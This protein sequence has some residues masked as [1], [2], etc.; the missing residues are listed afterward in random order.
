M[1]HII[2]Y[3]KFYNIIQRK[4]PCIVYFKDQSYN[5]NN[6]VMETMD[7]M[8]KIYPMVLCYEVNWLDRQKN[9]I[10]KIIKC[11]F[12]VICFK[13]SKFICKISPFN[14]SKLHF[15]FKTV[16]NDSVRNYMKSF[17]RI[18]KMEKNIIS[19]IN[20]KPFIIEIP[21][22]PII[23]NHGYCVK[24]IKINS[25]NEN[26]KEISHPYFENIDNKSI[27]VDNKNKNSLTSCNNKDLNLEFK[28]IDTFFNKDKLINYLLTTPV[29]IIKSEKEYTIDC[30]SIEK[31]KKVKYCT[32]K[33]SKEVE[34][35]SNKSPN[36][37][38]YEDVDLYIKPIELTKCKLSD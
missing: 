18:L 5:R 26:N 36:I 12:M 14:E 20:H 15:L 8:R 6:E 21:S 33:S 10:K 34:I 7:K 16:Y 23:N 35:T 19:Q 22:F 1:S 4:C 29:D 11:Q 24:D 37:P 3:S 9:T 31:Y 13:E 28:N 38:N 2:N 17:T 32:E 30:I 27:I 25:V